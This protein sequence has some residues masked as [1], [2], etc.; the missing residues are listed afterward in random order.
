MPRVQSRQGTYR[1]RLEFW[2]N[3]ERQHR[4]H[5]LPLTP[6]DFGRAVEAAFFDGLR[7]GV[8]LDYD[9]RPEEA[10]L[11]PRFVRPGGGSPR[12]EGFDVVLPTPAGGEHRV[13]FDRRLFRNLVRRTGSELVAAGKVPKD[14]I[15]LYQLAAYLDEAEAPRGSELVLDLEA[16]APEIP[17]RSASRKA[18]GPSQAWDG[19]MPEDFPVLIPRHVIDESVDE[20]RR[21]PDREVG[22]VLLGHLRRDAD[23]NELYLEVTA[24]VPAEETEA[25]ELSVT[26]THATW[27]RVREVIGV[28]G[29]GEIFVGWMHSHPFRFCQECPLPVPQEC[30]DKVLFYS[31]DDEFLMELSYPRPFMVGL[32]AAVEPRLE[33]ALGHAPVK[34]FGWKD[35]LI[36]ARGFEVIE[37]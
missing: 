1:F 22:G 13:G 28:R 12:A 19:P 31:S 36:E 33:A 11:E 4:V 25:T 10:V 8:F 5:E 15:L 34:L 35:G 24:L 23:T 27:A 21:A 16:E 17:I 20:A 26:F 29:E 9:F 30:I 18:L 2:K 32:L 6:A 7:R 37:G 3:K 14:S